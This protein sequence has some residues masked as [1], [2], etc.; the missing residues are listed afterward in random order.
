MKE[1]PMY[2]TICCYFQAFDQENY[3]LSCIGA[4]FWSTLS[5][6]YPGTST[7]HL[8]ICQFEGL[9]NLGHNL[10]PKLKMDSFNTR[11]EHRHSLLLI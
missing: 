10:I 2:T 11:G 4:F 9:C 3:D 5:F 6:L 1:N 7:H 8:I